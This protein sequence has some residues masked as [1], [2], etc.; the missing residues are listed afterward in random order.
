M[1]RHY[2]AAQY[3]ERVAALRDAVPHVNV[4]TDVIVG[5]PT[6]SREAFRRT[7]NLID[8]A[9]ITRVH[10]FSYSPRPGTAAEG[11]G[12][13][14]P[15]EEK[16]LRSRELRGH[17]EVR[18]RHHRAAK[19]GGVE[20]VLVDKVADTQCS[21]YTVDYTRCYL[22]PGAAHRGDV[23]SV[24]CEELHADGIRCGLYPQPS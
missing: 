5:F 8:A 22:L 21:G 1:G 3:L 11:L 10:A 6:E 12:D 24:R 2:T 16:K 19:L 13:H 18:S 15:P 9:Q 20:R 17:S 7:L 4:T 23:V 14:V